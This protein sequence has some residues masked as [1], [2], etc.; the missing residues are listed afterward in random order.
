MERNVHM[1]PDNKLENISCSILFFASFLVQL[2]TNEAKHQLDYHS[3][4]LSF[5]ASKQFGS[6]KLEF[7]NLWKVK[8][9]E[10]DLCFLNLTFF[11]PPHMNTHMLSF[12]QTWKSSSH[13]HFYAHCLFTLS[14]PHGEGFAQ[15]HL[16]EQVNWDSA[17]KVFQ[18]IWLWCLPE[19]PG[20]GFFTSLW[21]ES[22]SSPRPL[23]HQPCTSPRRG[24]R[25]GEGREMVFMQQWFISVQKEKDSL[26]Q[27]MCRWRE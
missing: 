12:T 13:T 10:S 24:G 15:R 5:V 2:N 16:S 22:S 4:P 25:R 19:A 21:F 11:S 26:F 14:C 23:K 7:E 8:N 27:S 3:N 1:V 20:N 9:N 17:L 6:A 18:V